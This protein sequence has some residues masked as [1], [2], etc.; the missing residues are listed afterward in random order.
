LFHCSGARKKKFLTDPV[1]IV[2]F[3]DQNLRKKVTK[4][5]P[6]EKIKVEPIKT[7]P[8]VERKVMTAPT[9]KLPSSSVSIKKMMEKKVE[10]KGKSVDFANMPRNDY[11]MDDLKMH[12]RR[13]AFRMKDEGK[14]TFYNAL[15]KREPIRKEQDEYV[16]EVDNQVQ[17]DYIVPILPDLLGYVRKSLNNYG[18]N[19]KMEITKN[20]EE[21]VKFLNGKDKFAAM[22]RKN[23]NMHTLKT[24]FNLDIEY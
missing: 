23:P 11:D 2:P 17:V 1:K 13:F 21:E 6:K 20:P 14:D 18:V 16:L 7:A 8:V 22:A 3:P 9:G 15:I 5:Q 12:W 24:L 19:I 10:E 4:V